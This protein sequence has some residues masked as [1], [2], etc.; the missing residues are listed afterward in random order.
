[1]KLAKL[2]SHLRADPMWEDSHTKNYSVSSLTVADDEGQVRAGGIVSSHVDA[3]VEDILQRGLICPITIDNDNV[4]VEGNH[5]VK[6]YEA[7]ARQNPDNPRWKLIRAFQRPFKTEAERRSYQ[8]ECNSHAP[9]KASTNEDYGQVVNNDL[10]AGVIPGMSWAS[11]NDDADNFNKLVDYIHSAYKQYGK[12]KNSAKAIAKIAAS[13]APNGKVKNY[14]KDELVKEFDLSN[15]IGWAGKKSGHDSN[16]VAIYAVGNSSHVF[17]NLTGNSFK[18]KTDDKRMSAGAVLWQ[19]NTF[20]E[21]GAG[22]DTWRQ[23]VVDSINEANKSWLLKP[24]AKLVDE[25]FI[26]PQK[27]REGR[28]DGKKFFRVKK[29]SNGE[30]DSSSI[31]T[32]GWE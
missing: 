20:G 23:G 14:T 26:A 24:D 9:A 32:D 19:S 11:F 2:M 6:A 16:G 5:R 3:L 17:P 21:T 15:C 8:L 29:K 4:V 30:F 22:L 28:E 27:L 7:L 31:P 25:V 18:K 10:K 13:A 1:M 12:S